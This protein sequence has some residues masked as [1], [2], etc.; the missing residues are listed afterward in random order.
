VAYREYLVWRGEQL[1]RHYA[2]MQRRLKAISPDIVVMTWSV[3]GGRYGHFLHSPR[4]MPTRM[5][6]LFDLP[7]QEWWLDETNVGS[8]LLPAF[9]AAYLRATTGRRLSGSE[10]Y[11][12]SH[13]NPYGTDS[14]PQVEHLARGMWVLTNGAVPPISFGWSGHRET[15]RQVLKEV[16]RRE[17][18]VTNVTDLPWAALLV[19]EQTRQFYAYRDIPGIFLPPLLGVFRTAYEEHLPLSLLNDWDLTPETLSKHRVLVLAGAA[20][21]SDEQVAAIRAYVE[22]GGGLVVTGE[23]S[24]CDELGRPRKDFALADVLGASYRGRPTSA[25]ASRD[26]DVNF[27]IALDEAYW[28]QRT[29]SAIVRWGE[30]ALWQDDRLKELVPHGQVRTRSPA[31]QVAVR[32]A[33]I[34]ADFVPDGSPAGTSYP[35]VLV[36]EH[37]QGRVVYFA[38]DLAAGYWT[39]SYPYQRRMLRQ[40]MTWAA[41]TAPPIT[42]RAPMSVQT[43][44]YQQPTERGKRWIVQRYNGVNTTASHGLPASEIPLREEIVPIHGIAFELTGRQPNRVTMQPENQPVVVKSAGERHTVELPPLELHDL[45]VIEWDK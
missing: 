39:Y 29:G 43:T 15:A 32:E 40:A 28:Q 1:E 2:E 11:L 16:E 9:G 24:L 4:A 25:A 13:G 10:P 14:F 45:V 7:M 33:D 35:G 26:I 20:A 31:V 8:S 42:V 38:T 12:M 3:N 34:A 18:W 41:G 44:F 17:P 23:T 21:L 27:A 36:R 30:H 37:G 6:L 5:N 22:G 19:S